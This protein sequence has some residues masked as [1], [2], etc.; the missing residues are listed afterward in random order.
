[1]KTEKYAINYKYY[2]TNKET[3]LVPLNDVLQSGHRS[4]NSLLLLALSSF[5]VYAVNICAYFL[6]LFLSYNYYIPLDTA[7]MGRLLLFVVIIAF[8]MWIGPF[9]LVFKPH[10]QNDYYRFTTISNHKKKQNIGLNALLYVVSIPLSIFGMLIGLLAMFYGLFFVICLPAYLISVNLPF[11][12]KKKNIVF[13]CAQCGKKL[14]GSALLNEATCPNGGKSHQLDRVLERGDYSTL[15]RI[16]PIL[17][18]KRPNFYLELILA[19]VIAVGIYIAIS[20]AS[21][22]G[23]LY[24]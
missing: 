19:V 1:M 9:F 24:E 18:K 6:Y 8:I 4:K 10:F 14:K 16:Y 3:S 23:I 15:D 20:S 12:A 7:S 11:Q 2:L 22:H 13:K 5:L 17:H 21:L